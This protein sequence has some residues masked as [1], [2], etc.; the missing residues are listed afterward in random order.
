MTEI[1]NIKQEVLPYGSLKLYCICGKEV[2]CHKW[3]PVD[4]WN[5]IIKGFENHAKLEEC[6]K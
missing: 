3:M 5:N 4:M 6:K 2:L 1:H